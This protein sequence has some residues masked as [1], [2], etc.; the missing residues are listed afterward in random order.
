MTHVYAPE[1]V[2]VLAD[3]TLLLTYG[4]GLYWIHT[5]GKLRNQE[6]Q[7]DGTNAAVLAGFPDGILVQAYVLNTNRPVYWVPLDDTGLHL[8]RKLRVT[9]ASGVSVNN[10]RFL[11]KGNLVV[12][13]ERGSLHSFNIKTRQTH[14][15]RT[16]PDFGPRLFDGAHVL[17]G[18]R[19][20]DLNGKAYPLEVFRNI[21]E[22]RR[23]FGFY[24]IGRSVGRGRV[25]YTYYSVDFRSESRTAEPKV[26]GQVTRRPDLGAPRR[27]GGLV[28]YELRTKQIVTES[29]II[30]WNGTRWSEI[31]LPSLP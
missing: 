28:G 18:T 17:Q 27:S 30:V 23:N 31:P 29:G 8:D 14:S 16:N 24:A 1:V 11:R 3:G 25:D 22:I 21:F 15:T 12:W 10:S 2:T 4:T 19:L 26:L 7:V 6:V 5:D 9:D 20:Y 13:Q